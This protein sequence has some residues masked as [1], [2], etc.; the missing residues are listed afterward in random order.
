VYR[1]AF[2]GKHKAYLLKP[3]TV[4]NTVKKKVHIIQA[5]LHISL[6]IKQLGQKTNCV[7]YLNR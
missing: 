5:I 4:D 2:L 7:I 3:D 1:T 6:H